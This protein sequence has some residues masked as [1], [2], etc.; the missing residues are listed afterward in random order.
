MKAMIRDA[1]GPPDVLELREID[2]P[3]RD[4]TKSCGFEIFF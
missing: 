1:Y 2:K 4:I 3:E